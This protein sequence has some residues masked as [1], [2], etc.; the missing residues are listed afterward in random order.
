MGFKHPPDLLAFLSTEVPVLPNC[1]L[2][3]S[4][5]SVS[6]CNN[7]EDPPCTTLSRVLNITQ[8]VRTSSNLD[9]L[10]ISPCRQQ[11][12]QRIH[13]DNNAV[14]TGLLGNTN[15]MVALGSPNTTSITATRNLCP[16]RNVLTE[17]CL[18]INTEG[19]LPRLWETKQ[20]L[21]EV[22]TSVDSLCLAW[23]RTALYTLMPHSVAK[24][25]ETTYGGLAKGS[26]T[27]TGVEVIS[28]FTTS[29]TATNTTTS[30]LSK[31]TD[32]N[33]S[34]QMPKSRRLAYMS[35]LA[36][37]SSDAR[38]LRQRL[39]RRLP[40]RTT[41]ATSS[42]YPPRL[43]TSFRALARHLVNANAGIMY[44][45]GCPIIRIDTW[46]PSPVSIPSEF[47][48][49]NQSP[50]LNNGIN[51]SASNETI[52]HICRDLCVTFTTYAGQLSLTFSASSKQSIH[53]NLDL[54]IS[55]IKSQVITFK[56][57]DNITFIY[58]SLQQ[59]IVAF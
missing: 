54:I 20:R 23:A 50:E 33:Y 59:K 51:K 55:G 58:V 10:N 52:V 1:H 26:V 2:N 14:E 17:F 21:T 11:Q 38:I 35:L 36:N 22:N 25:I 6:N 30:N 56:L 18:P 16:G 32:S 47:I 27:I 49:N 45:A 42:V 5:V 31:I 48:A 24:W 9:F 19:M 29:T 34:Y 3:T 7:N 15:R 57:M 46:M 53:P 12:Q 13:H 40:R 43:G 37:K 4:S 8:R 28:P 44:I 41:T 39:R